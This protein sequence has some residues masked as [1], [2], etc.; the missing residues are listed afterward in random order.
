LNIFAT[1]SNPRISAIWLDDLRANKMILESCQLM[2]TAIH[3]IHPDHELKLYKPFNPNHPCCIWTRAG[4]ENF[5][6][7]LDHTFAL[8]THR[9][10]PE[11]RSWVNYDTCCVWFGANYWRLPKLDLLTFQN[12]AA[13]EGA[14]INY[15]NIKDTHLAYRL[16]L[17]HRWKQDKK[18]PTWN[19]GE[20]PNW[21]ELN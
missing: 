8:L 5:K 21:C 9:A 7:L 13:N 15:K 11:H 2:S 17:N 10:K 6:W 12:C 4:R 18:P 14:G 16:Y 19:T 20:K 1:H 3:L